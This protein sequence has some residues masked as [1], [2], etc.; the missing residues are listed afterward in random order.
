M[1]EEAGGGGNL[2]G[3]RKRCTVGEKCNSEEYT[4]GQDISNVFFSACRGKNL[5]FFKSR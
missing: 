3:D 2:D 5:P 4:A 1:I